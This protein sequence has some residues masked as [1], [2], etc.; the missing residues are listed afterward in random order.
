LA[1]CGGGTCP[2]FGSFCLLL[3]DEPDALLPII[4]FP[5]AQSRK[6]TLIAC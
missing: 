4:G 1:F 5:P 2:E 3:D 6:S